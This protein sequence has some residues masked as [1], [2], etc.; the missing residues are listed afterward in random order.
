MK[1]NVLVLITVVMGFSLA[2]IAGTISGQVG[3]LR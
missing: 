2:A 3:G 1:R